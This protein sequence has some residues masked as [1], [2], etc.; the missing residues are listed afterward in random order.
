VE[1]AGEV[2]VVGGGPLGVELAAEVKAHWPQKAVT[3]AH[4]GVGAVSWRTCA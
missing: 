4:A 2:L 3:L 1:R